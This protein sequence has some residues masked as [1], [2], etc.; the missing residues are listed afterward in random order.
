MLLNIKNVYKTLSIIMNKKKLNLTVTAGKF[1]RL[2]SYLEL[3]V[4]H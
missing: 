2:S 1:V 3:R 4:N